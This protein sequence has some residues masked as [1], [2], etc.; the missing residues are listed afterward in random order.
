MAKTV[1]ILDRMNNQNQFLVPGSA[2]DLYEI[3]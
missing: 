3:K 1:Q 2:K